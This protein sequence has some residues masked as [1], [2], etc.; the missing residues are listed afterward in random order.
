M[1]AWVHGCMG[2]W[3]HESMGAWIRV[4]AY[5]RTENEVLSNVRFGK[6]RNYRS[7]LFRAFVGGGGGVW[8]EARHGRF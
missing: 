8:R 7:R 6:N 4:V 2:A 1:G 5:F 3:V